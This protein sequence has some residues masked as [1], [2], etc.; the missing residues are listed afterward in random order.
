MDKSSEWLR[1]SRPAA[2]RAVSQSNTV[3]NIA[4]S[5]PRV[6]LHW[7]ASSSLVRQGGRGCRLSRLP[8]LS[9]A[10]PPLSTAG[11]AMD[12][13]VASFDDGQRAVWEF[14]SGTTN[15]AVVG[16]AGCGKS[17]VL[18]PCISDARRRFGDDAVLVM[19]WTWVAAEKIDGQ[20]FHS[21]LGITPVESSRERSLEMV[22]SKPGI[23]TKLE[24]SRVV[25]ID[26]AFTF[27]GSHFV[28]L[29]YVSRCLSPAHMQGDP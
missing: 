27:S 10:T 3:F 15:V 25:F 24:Q 5:G 22:R 19:A 29:E 11:T 17:Q 21:Y 9:R 7:R 26:E 16:P 14:F 12:A 28:E 13:C 20:S 6:C 2:S 18:L 23:C 8:S 4:I 1:N